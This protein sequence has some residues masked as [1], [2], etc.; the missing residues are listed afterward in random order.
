MIDTHCHLYSKE[1]V[2]DLHDVISAADTNGVL[3]FYMPAIDSSTTDAM[4]KVEEK[5]PQVCSMIGL[6]PCSVNGNYEQELRHVEEWLNKRKFAA[7]GEIGLDFYWDKTF[8]HQQYIAFRKQIA[9]ALDQQLQ[10]VIHSRNATGETISVIKEYQGAGLK[11]IFHCFGG[12][13]EEAQ[14]II[15]AGFLLGIGGVVTYKNA[16]LAEVLKEIDIKHLVLETDAPYLAPAPFRGKRNE[17]SYLQHI[18]KK[19]AEIKNISQEEVARI[20]T[21]NALTVFSY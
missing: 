1:F 18:A 20:T 19:I 8:I 6:H 5:Y 13:L 9:F 14:E 4:L 16:G 11:G 7:V 2:D 3:R 15:N 12:S 10:I 21:E 17:S